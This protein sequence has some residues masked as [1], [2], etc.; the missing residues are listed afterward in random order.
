VGAVTCRG[1]RGSAR[2]L[3]RSAEIQVVLDAAS[4]ACGAGNPARSRL[5]AGIYR[6]TVGA[7]CKQV[8]PKRAAA[9]TTGCPT[10]STEP[11]KLNKEPVYGYLVFFFFTKRIVLFVE[12][13]VIFARDPVPPVSEVDA[14][15][16]VNRHGF[17]RTRESQALALR[18][19][20]PHPRS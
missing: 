7:P 10:L 6:F 17:R 2:E 11:V 4:R 8:P 9:A 12:V 19:S 16:S 14:T 18:A 1:G 13:L 15:N 20:I 3:N 5:S